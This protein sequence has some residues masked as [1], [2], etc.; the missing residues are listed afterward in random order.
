MLATLERTEEIDWFEKA[1]TEPLT[2]LY[3]RLALELVMAKSSDYVVFMLDLNGFKA[4]NDTC[5]HEVGDRVLKAIARNLRTQTGYDQLFRIGGDEFIALVQCNESDIPDIYYRLKSAVSSTRLDGIP[6]MSLK[7]H[8]CG[9][10]IGFALS[11]E[12]ECIKR[13]DERMFKD[14]KLTKELFSKLNGT[15]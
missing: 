1:T 7:G 15:T 2:G 9:T 10:S 6:G 5:G 14:K 8:R 12:E 13:A 4:I 11:S 3:S